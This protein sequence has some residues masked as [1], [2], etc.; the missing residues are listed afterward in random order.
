MRVL[1]EPHQNPKGRTLTQHG[2]S[3][4]VLSEC[5]NAEIDPSARISVI[6]KG[7]HVEETWMLCQK[8]HRTLQ[9]NTEWATVVRHIQYWGDETPPKV[10]AWAEAMFGLKDCQITVKVEE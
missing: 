10:V 7:K 5:C 3:L 4:F 9:A 1:L 6:R 2:T 8:C